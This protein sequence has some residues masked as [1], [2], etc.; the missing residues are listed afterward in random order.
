LAGK[1]ESFFPGQRKREEEV[2]IFDLLTKP[3]M[4]LKKENWFSISKKK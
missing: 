3:E 2:A 4:T 1:S